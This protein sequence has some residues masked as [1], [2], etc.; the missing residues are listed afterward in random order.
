MPKFSNGK[1]T[2]T[3]LLYNRGVPQDM[4]RFALIAGQNYSMLR[5][6]VRYSKQHGIKTLSLF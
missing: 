6:V 1:I 5:Q 3:A 4:K 2:S